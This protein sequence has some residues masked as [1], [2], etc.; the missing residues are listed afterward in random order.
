MLPFILR[1]KDVGMQEGSHFCSYLA[2]FYSHHCPKALFQ[3]PSVHYSGFLDVCS[4]ILSTQDS[5]GICKVYT[6][7]T[8]P[9]SASCSTLHVNTVFPAPC[10]GVTLRRLHMECKPL[11]PTTETEWQIP[12]CSGFPSWNQFTLITLGEKL[13]IRQ[14]SLSSS[15]ATGTGGSG[16]IQRTSGGVPVGT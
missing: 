5:P 15:P 13:L 3:T 12:T 7:S 6:L 4:R 11:A 1:G 10:A 9:L 2:T 8:H 16:V 14:L